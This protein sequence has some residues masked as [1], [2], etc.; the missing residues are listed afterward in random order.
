MA[1]S[2]YDLSATGLLGDPSAGG[3]VTLD[4]SWPGTVLQQMRVASG[5]GEHSE[6]HACLS[7]T[8]SPIVTNEDAAMDS[9]R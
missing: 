4:T 6:E 5:G 9:A 7:D 2:L 8:C 3:I 1:R